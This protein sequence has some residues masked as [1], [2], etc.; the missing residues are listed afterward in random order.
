M[1]GTRP[2]QT[3]RDGKGKTPLAC[4]STTAAIMCGIHMRSGSLSVVECSA[5][6]TCVSLYGQRM[7]YLVQLLLRMAW[8]C[9]QCC[10]C[11]LYRT[12]LTI[13]E[14]LRRNE[15]GDA[16]CL[17]MLDG[18]RVRTCPSGVRVTIET[19]Q[20][21]QPFRD[22][23]CLSSSFVIKGAGTGQRAET[24]L[25]RGGQAFELSMLMP[26]CRCEDSRGRRCQSR[27]SHVMV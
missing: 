18:N 13:A 23:V 11:A 26:L 3:L 8:Q 10:P 17:T 9:Q 15:R 24:D 16:C 1:C 14:K 22:L 2:T 12:M 4:H 6:C 19:Y 7:R 27:N 20:V 21:S 25:R 5:S